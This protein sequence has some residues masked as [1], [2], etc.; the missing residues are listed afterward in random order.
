MII[1][2]LL[3]LGIILISLPSKNVPSSQFNFRQFFIYEIIGIENKGKIIRWMIYLMV[4]VNTLIAVFLPIDL[5]ID[6]TITSKYYYLMFSGFFVLAEIFFVFLSVLS[7][8]KE[9]MRI[10]SF[11]LFGSFLA[12]T[13]GTAAI[14]LFSISRKTTNNSIMSLIFGVVCVLFAL[15]SF[16]PMLNPKLTNYA[17]LEH[18][19]EEDGSVHLERPKCI[20]MALSEWIFFFIME[21]SFLTDI[22]FFMLT[23]K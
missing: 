17:K 10:T 1:S 21:I 9:R 11:V 5:P 4:S 8:R 6:E 13:N 18:I 22:V 7:F 14:I 19:T 16:I 23:C 20:F 12:I 3:F 15:A 2:F